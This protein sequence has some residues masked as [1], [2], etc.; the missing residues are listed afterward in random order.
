MKLAP[1]ERAVI[2]LIKTRRATSQGEISRFLNLSPATV[3]SLL[4]RLESSHFVC[5]DRRARHGRGR[6][7]EHY[8]IKRPD[9]V[10]AIHWHDSVWYGAL[11]QDNQLKGGI[12][13]G[14]L[15]VNANLEETCLAIR[16]ARDQIL[17]QD[18]LAGCHPVGIALHMNAVQTTA[19]GALASS[20]IPWV[21]NVSAK[22]FSDAIGSKV[23]LD[24]RLPWVIPELRARASNGIHSL[25][26]LNV[27]NGVSAHGCVFDSEWGG[28][29]FYGG[30][31]GHMVID[32]KGP[33]CGCGHRGCVE[34][35]IS[36][37]AILRRVT[38][39]LKDGVQT[40]LLGSLYFGRHFEKCGTAALDCAPEGKPSRHGGMPH[41]ESVVHPGDR[42]VSP[43][44]LTP[45]ALFSELYRLHL[46]GTDSYTNTLAEEFLDRVA[47]S[48][49][50]ILSTI[51]PDVIVLSGYALE[52]RETWRQRIL[53]SARS[54]VLW[55][56][57]SEIRLEFPLVTKE[58]YL[59]YIANAFAHGPDSPGA[60]SA[61]TSTPISLGR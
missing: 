58:D 9:P 56:E 28:E 44:R 54:R 2:Q 26:V 32:P 40:Q 46:E 55:G 14:D 1:T 51:G 53:K 31:L 3:H 16:R 25:V 12:L 22:Q 24:L 38:A 52:G 39:D 42:L 4:G 36:G 23:Q 35:I 50:V 19:D 17:A 59:R 15:P 48:V 30:E 61:L 29:R 7:V 13:A 60:A 33:L 11:F 41:F 37:P 49:A 34:S 21:R 5:R 18:G 57:S 47:W 43:V 8:R 20:V 45:A 10:L 6:P 27:A